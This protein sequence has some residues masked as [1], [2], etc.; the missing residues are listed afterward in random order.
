MAHPNPNS[1]NPDGSA[2]PRH[3]SEIE[4]S[5]VISPMQHGM[6]F[7]NLLHPGT[8][9]YIR[10][11]IYAL[12]EELDVPA[13]RQA[14]QNA[15]RRHAILRTSL[16]W[17]GLDEPV[18]EVHRHISVPFEESDWRGLSA[19]EH[20]AR[21]EDFLQAERRR[22]FDLSEPPLMRLRLFRIANDDYQLVWTFHHILS[23]GTSD[24]LLLKEVFSFYEALRTGQAVE[25][26]SAPSYRDYTEWLRRQD[27]TAAKAHWRRVFERF[28][29]PTPLPVAFAHERA[30][31][32]PVTGEQAILLSVEL[33][34]ALKSFAQEHELTLNTLMQGAWALLL[35]AYSGE[36]DIVFGAARACRRSALQGQGAEKIVGPFINILPVRVRVS[37]ARSLVDWLKE[38]RDQWVAMRDY[39]HTPMV[40]LQEWSDLGPGVSLFDSIVSFDRRQMKTSLQ[41][42]GGNWLR[43]ELRSIQARTNY[44]LALTGYGEDSFLLSLRYDSARFDDATIRRMLGNL[45]RTFEGF[46]GHADGRLSDVSLL[47]EAE[48]HQ[49]LR[50][51]NSTAS[52]YP[53]EVCVHSLFETQVER[54]PNA[55]AVVFQ[56]A[57]LTYREL[58]DKANQIAHRLRALGVGV[59]DRVGLLCDRSLELVTGM[60]GI[61][62]AGGAYVALD[63][64]SPEERLSSILKDARVRVLLTQSR[65]STGL[66]GCVEHTICL[67]KDWQSIAGESTQQPSSNVSA[68]NAAY[69]IYTSGSTGQPKG[70]VIE[71]RNLCNLIFWHRRAFSITS[72]DRA[73]QLAGLG[74]DASVWEMWPYL[75]AGAS[76]YLLDEETRLSPSCLTSWLVRKG[77]TMCFLPTPLAEEVLSLSFPPDTTLRFMLTG[78]DKLH[79]FPSDSLPFQLVNNYGPTENTVVTTSGLV[80]NGEQRLPVPSIGRPI[81][82]TQ[83]YLLSKHRHPVPI[84]APGELYIGGEGLA[85]GYLSR[86]D[87]T[88]ESFV[89]NP[90]QQA[91]GARLYRTGDRVHFLPDGTIEF[92]GRVD[93]QVKIRGFRIELGEIE[94]ALHQSP[95][96][97]QC[98]VVAREDRPG[99]KYLA[100]YIVVNGQADTSGAALSDF[101][102]QRLPEHM[103]PSVFVMMDKLPVTAN[104]KL[105][106]QSLPA[107]DESQLPRATEFVAPRSPVEESLVQVWKDVLGIER[108]G[109]HDNFFE[110][111]GNSLLVVRLVSR[112]RQIFH[113]DLPLHLLFEAP[114][115]AQLAVS[116]AQAQFGN[117]EKEGK[118]V[119]RLLE[120]LEQLPNEAVRALLDNE[121]S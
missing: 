67:D 84:G 99:N 7:H 25:L 94:A 10:Q 81:A 60:L 42:L 70:V 47:T 114:T 19:L 32:S 34:S 53:R 5:Y 46:V 30:T 117:Q 85:R 103:I 31:L 86:P 82:N 58:N 4:D 89:P 118:D 66:T 21:L 96:V 119:E 39:E 111:K 28:T 36:E 98:A 9:M 88:A 8:E 54:A 45:Q 78:G 35:S 105:D 37:A 101:L 22:G 20:E 43:R 18:Q 26:K 55:S 71:H 38:L 12:H 16:R 116:I 75:A 90:F 83:V 57:C 93:N 27:T 48:L 33:T 59:E 91:F 65:L 100:A 23:D 49:S 13:L 40:K 80:L 68:R 95:A 69:V 97:K 14:W 41:S 87:L 62:K 29:A 44:A 24:V 1:S 17:E 120:E 11:I 56:N 79:C 61:L 115:V 64:A 106:R 109:V 51:W 112:L 2:T 108:V 92:L 121:Q 110:L 76:V 3:S 52:D 113:V 63:P 72:D 77:I 15:V 50:E 102:R 6:L 104:G 107:P 74:F 73:T